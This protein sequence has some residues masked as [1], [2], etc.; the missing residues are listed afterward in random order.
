MVG[1][2][3]GLATSG[4]PGQD[5]QNTE[6]TGRNPP[7]ARGAATAERAP[8]FRMIAAE[9]PD[10]GGKVEARLRTL[11]EEAQSQAASVDKFGSV[12]GPTGDRAPPG[13]SVDA[14]GGASSGGAITDR[15]TL[16]RGIAA[17]REAVD[18]AR[19]APFTTA[20]SG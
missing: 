8:A 3:T 15:H 18:L 19:I 12:V 6:V 4:P 7:T 5:R 9:R 16:I 17:Y 13:S 11:V 1:S 14:S 10:G 20:R 2:V